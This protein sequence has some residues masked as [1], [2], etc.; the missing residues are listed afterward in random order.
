MDFSITVLP[1][2]GIGPEVIGEAV[3]VMDAVGRRFGHDFGT[4]FGSVGGNAIDEFGTPLP[5]ET[6]AMCKKTDGILFG[7]VGGPKWDDPRA[8]TRPEDGILAI[9]KGLG[10]FANLRPV[11]V[12]PEL[13]NSSPIKPALLEGVDMIVV[14]ELTGG[15]YF[16]KPKKRWETS[17]GRRGVDTLRYT[18]QTPRAPIP[19]SR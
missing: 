15:L 10:L 14:R 3:K 13:I 17:R 4:S 8:K 5:E 1:G 18:E 12:F 16:A 2:D 19:A 9:R 11:K 7:A 6:L